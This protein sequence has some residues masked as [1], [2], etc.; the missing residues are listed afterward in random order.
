MDI[1]GR[2]QAEEA[3]RE[4]EA[5]L[6]LALDGARMVTWEWDVVADSATHTAGDEELSYM[7]APHSLDDFLSVIEEQDREAVRQ[8]L[9]RTVDEGAEYNV[10]FRLVRGRGPERWMFARGTPLFD[11]AGAVTRLVGVATDISER[12]R[13][14]E[15]LR[16][17]EERYRK[18][19]QDNPSMYF[20][21][22]REGTILSVNRFG[23]EILGYE[24]SE[25][26]GR[27]VFD[28]FHK[29]DRA[30][31]RRQLLYLANDLEAVRSWEF[32]KVR[33][34]GQEIWVRE[35]VRATRDAEGQTIF[36]VVC[37]DITERRRI[38]DTMQA[39]REQLERR[40][41]RAVAG[42]NR[43]NLSFREMTVLD[44][45]ADGKSDKE[46][47][48]VL[49]IRPMTVSKHVANVLKKM[50]AASRAEAGVRAWREGII[51]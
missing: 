45:V 24:E 15:A 27:S 41:D 10:E 30:A 48:V 51:K 23:A 46:I 33:K 28:V 26:V 8:A 13:A 9:R 2:K 29:A 49:G 12:K 42:G 7:S 18:L 37:E 39:L 34:D 22:A 11:G 32:R 20:T 25:L 14:E 36:L 31:V 40:A 3:L 43:Y 4:S 44:Q 16:G 5:R 6:R 19:Y 21:V 47:G 1:T 50:G 35:I 38:E 17:S